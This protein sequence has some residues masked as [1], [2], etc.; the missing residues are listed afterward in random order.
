MRKLTAAGRIALMAG[1]ALAAAGPGWAAKVAGKQC[2]NEAYERKDANG[3]T[4][5]VCRSGGVIVS[6]QK[7]EKGPADPGGPKGEA[8]L[9]KPV[10]KA[11]PG[12]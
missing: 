11:T 4:Y 5:W 1:L 9:T 10:D 12:K 7:T 3:N 6:G 2:D 8:N